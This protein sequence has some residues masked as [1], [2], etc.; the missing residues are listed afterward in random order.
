MNLYFKTKSKE[1]YVSH[2]RVYL[3][4]YENKELT[5]VMVYG[6]SEEMPMMLLTNK[7]VRNKNEVH[8]IVRNYMKRWR[9]EE[10]FRYKKQ[11]Y[12]FEKKL[13]K[14]IHS[15]QVMNEILMVHIGHITMLVEQMD[16]K[17]LVI[18]VIERSQALSKKS[19][20]WL[21][22]IRQGIKDYHH[23]RKKEAFKQLAIPI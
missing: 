18:K 2:T 13:L 11:E 17:L 1:A 16:R 15:M 12:G 19:Y 7:K 20:L 21:Y 6:L 5:L 10:G 23:I 3:P 8:N 4:A 14:T 9:I 22:R